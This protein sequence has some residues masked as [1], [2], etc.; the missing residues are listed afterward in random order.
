MHYAATDPNAGATPSI[1]GIG[2]AGLT[3]P[4]M[5]HTSSASS[6]RGGPCEDLLYAIDA[7]LAELV[8]SCDPDQGEFESIGPI[9]V[10]IARCS[11]IKVAPDGNIMAIVLAESGNLLL[12]LDRLTG[13]ATSQTPVNDDSPIQAFGFVPERGERS[14][15]VSPAAGVGELVRADRAVR[16]LAASSGRAI[17][18]ASP[19]R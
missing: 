18:C 15:R 16:S 17:D 12:V 4:V 6:L 8:M 2:F 1:S 19:H 3:A 5:L 11:E 7:D 9:A 14:L 13:H 10:A